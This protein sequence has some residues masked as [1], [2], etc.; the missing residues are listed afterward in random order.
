EQLFERVKARHERAAADAGVR[1]DVS[2]D[3]A[4]AV[5][6]ADRDRL[7]QALQNLAAN[8]VRHAPGGT[9]VTLASRPADEAGGVA[10][11]VEDQGPGIAPEH[12]P[13]I[14]DRFYKADAA[15][16]GVSGGS[17]LGLSIV[18]AIVERHGGHIAARGGPAQTVFE[19]V[20]PMRPT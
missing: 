7:E 9:A 13:Y 18:K 20:L 1:F 2:I 3:P 11:T 5:A 14:F 19:V 8:A 6:I 15:R 10:L 16:A 12:L 4:A 17:G